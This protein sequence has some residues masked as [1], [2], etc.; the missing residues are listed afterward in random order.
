MPYLCAFLARSLSTGLTFRWRGEHAASPEMLLEYTAVERIWHG[1]YSRGPADTARRL[2]GLDLACGE[3]V[4]V[5]MATAA[6][7]YGFDTEN[8]AELHV[9]NPSGHQLRPADGLVVHRRDGAPLKL[10]AGRPTTAPAWTAIEVARTLRRLR[11]LATLDAALRSRRCDLAAL[12]CAVAAQKGR[13]GVVKVPP[14]ASDCRRPS[15]VADGKRGPPRH[16]RWRVP[17]PGLAA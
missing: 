8:G 6:R 2:K 13:R 10:L 5:C 14:F 3:V 16:D 4:G 1:V 15:R 9:L 7:A 11:A 17:Q 12:S